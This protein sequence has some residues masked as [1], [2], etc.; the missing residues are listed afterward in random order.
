MRAVSVVI[1]STLVFLF[2]CKKSNESYPVV[3]KLEYK[4]FVAYNKYEAQLV[5]KFTDG[6]GDIGLKTSDTTGVYDKSGPYY[7]NLYIKTFYK[8]S[9]GVFKDTA[10]YDQ[11]TNTIDTGLIRQRVQ[12]VEK[13][14]KE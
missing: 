11:I 1:I 8:G 10:L 7:Y 3:P 12:Y 6:D 4:S 14:N 2:S 9:N 13:N 5:I